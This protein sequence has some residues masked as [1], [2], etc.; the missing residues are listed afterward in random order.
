MHLSLVCLWCSSIE[1]LLYLAV[2]ISLDGGM[3][4]C[5]CKCTYLSSALIAASLVVCSVL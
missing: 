1:Q 3:A 5:A 4:M 2:V